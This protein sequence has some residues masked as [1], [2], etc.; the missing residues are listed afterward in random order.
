MPGALALGS[1]LLAL[2]G[3]GAASAQ[4][5]LRVVNYRGYAVR[6]PRSW[7]VYDLARAPQTC[8]RFNRHAVYLGT[9]STSQ[10][11]PIASTSPAAGGSSPARYRRPRSSR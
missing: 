6:I 5:A 11:C 10:S 3:T 4:P 9:P 1:A 8:V 7:P 2:F